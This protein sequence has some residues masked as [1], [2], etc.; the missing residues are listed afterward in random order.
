MFGNIRN[1]MQL[2]SKFC[3]GDTIVKY[4][5]D[6]TG[7]VG[8]LLL[9]AE[10]EGDIAD[11]RTTLNDEPEVIVMPGC[12]DIAARPVDSLV[13]LKCIGDAYPGG[14]A[15]GRT[16]RNSESVT[17]MKYLSQ[18]IN[19]DDTATVITTTLIREGRY[20]CRHVLTNYH[21]EETFDVYTVFENISGVEIALEMLS[22]FSLGGLS[23][24]DSE[25][26]SEKLFMHRLRCSWS[27]EGRHDCVSLEDMQLE[28]SWAGFSANCERFGEVGSKAVRSFF[29]FLAIEDREKGVFWGAQLAW[30]GT[31]Q[32]EVYRRNDAAAM[33][34][35]LGD[36]E[37]G[38]WV[39][40]IGA[41]ESFATP[42]A[43]IAVA[44]GDID[45]ICRRL[46][47]AQKR[48]IAG[49]PEIEKDLPIVFNEWCTTWGTPS[50]ENIT[51]I[52][53]RIKDTGIKYFVIDAGWYK[54]RSGD[55]QD[56]QGDWT[57]NRDLFPDG[58]KAAAEAIRQRGMVPGLWFEMEVCGPLSNAVRELDHLL[59]KR[60]GLTI[61]SGNRRFFDFRKPETIDYLSKRVIGLLEEC[62]FGYLKIDYNE[63]IG[64]GADGDESLGEGLRKHV[65]G[66]HDFI[67]KIR[68]RLP[69][70]VIENCS[71]GG[72]RL[73]PLMVAATHMSSFSDCHETKEIPVV[74]ANMHRMILPAQS[75]V[76]AVL[77]ETDDRSRLNYSLAAT[78][79]GRMCISGDILTL[80]D[81]QF[82]LM[83]RYIRLYADIK[84][85]IR[86]GFSYRFGPE[87]RSIRHAKGWQAILRVM[88][89]KS[90]ALLVVHSFCSPVPEKAE[91]E[92]PA[93]QWNIGQ[94]VSDE[95][96][97]LKVAGSRIDIE[98]N[99]EYASAVAVLIK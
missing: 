33:S 40:N 77:R 30:S 25:D 92:L 54:S 56:S 58:L 24:F 60:D 42:V 74:A 18:D 91:I 75:Q 6:N 46:T 69:E 9:P 81:E 84:D 73:D 86:D 52:A 38:H 20:L 11:W 57:A 78:L 41:G 45:T 36:R 64:I 65:Q 83:R 10:L 3:F 37:F 7:A 47:G 17:A 32:M 76:W 31:W 19:K 53:D 94:M 79:L 28:R 89:D 93:G 71:S 70:L 27:S 5:T 12:V 23:P 90:R 61:V 88:P 87:L 15:Q 96:I 67:G 55:W 39:T 29:P 2:I 35:G 80:S 21:G 43:T 1:I 68:R 95:N 8:L 51:K 97:C 48:R 59:L 63:T 72:Q 4:I 49:S 22:S 82:A 26:A 44:R 66:V 98:F 14:L 34:G 50:H 62:G 13:Q 99:S 16:M 85:I